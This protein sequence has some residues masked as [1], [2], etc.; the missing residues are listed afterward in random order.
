MS[1]VSSYLPSRYQ[2]SVVG[3]FLLAV[4]GGYIVAALT[5]AMLVLML[6][7][8]AVDAV[9]LSTTLSV[10]FYVCFFL[11]VFASNKLKTA[12]AVFFV[13]SL[14]HL[15]VISLYRDLL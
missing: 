14:L 4:I 3:R 2:F 11:Y 6:P 15:T 9:L 10:L 8:K 13:L 5:S 12:F 1:I 7:I